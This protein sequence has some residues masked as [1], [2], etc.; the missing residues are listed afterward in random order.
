MDKH[1]SGVRMA[2]LEIVVLQGG[3]D[4]ALQAAVVLE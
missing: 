2:L 1:T 4:L 3:P